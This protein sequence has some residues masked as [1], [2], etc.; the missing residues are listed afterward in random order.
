MCVIFDAAHESAR[1]TQTAFRDACVVI[2]TASEVSEASENSLNFESM[3]HT[4]QHQLLC[5]VY[6]C[7][8]DLESVHSSVMQRN[9]LHAH[10]YSNADPFGDR[11]PES[12]RWC[13]NEWL[14]KGDVV[15]I[16]RCTGLDGHWYVWA[17]LIC[18]CSKRQFSTQTQQSY[19]RLSLIIKWW[20][21]VVKD[22]FDDWRI[23]YSWNPFG[24]ESH[25][26]CFYG[27]I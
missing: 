24:N 2:K 25:L 18:P 23:I 19:S 21:N 17:S 27:W 8:F 6:K 13:S 9:Y 11:I 10:N 3:S 4:Q 1:V 26:Q 14:C 5:S 22:P 12:L 15:S 7:R 20:R 16:L